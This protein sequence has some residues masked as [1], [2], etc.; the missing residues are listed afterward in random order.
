MT[1][2]LNIDNKEATSEN[3]G[4]DM[5]ILTEMSDKFDTNEAER[6][7][8]A[9]KAKI[10]ESPIAKEQGTS[11]FEARAQLK[12]FFEQKRH[13]ENSDPAIEEAP[14]EQSNN[15][16]NTAKP[17]T[18]SSMYEAM[19][20]PIIDKIKSE[21]QPYN[22]VKYERKQVASQPN[23]LTKTARLIAHKLGLETKRGKE[24]R[25]QEAIHIALD[26]YRE[27]E[28]T[29]RKALEERRKALEERKK[30]E[31]LERAKRDAE[32]KAEMAKIEKR[33]LARD[34]ETAR[35]VFDY[36]KHNKFGKQRIQEIVE[37]GLNSRLLTVDGL[38]ME[39]ISEN[40]E[41]QKRSISFEDADIPV[42]DLKGFPFSF[43]STTIDY[44]NA[45]KPGEIGTETFEKILE[46]PSIWTERRDEAEKASG[47]GTRNSDARG[48][49]ISTSYWNSERNIDSRVPGNLIYGFESV[50][51]DSIISASNGDGATNNMAGG[52]KTT[53]SSPNVIERLEGADG[54]HGYNEILLR[55][56]TENGM[57]K[58]PDYI[59]T[60]NGKITE[61]S[62]RHAKYFD[63]PI[64]NIDRSVYA[65]KTEKRGEE[66]LASI[67]EDDAYEEIDEKIAELL[68]ISKYK[69]AYRRLEGIGRNYDIPHLI[70]PTPL[71]KRCLEISQMEQLKRLEFIKNALEEATDNIESATEKGLE[72]EQSFPKFESFDIYIIDVR[73]QLWRTESSDQKDSSYSA[74]GNCNSINIDFRLKGSSR[75]VT[76]NVYDGAR[77]YKAEEA[78]NQTKEDMQN[79][80]SSYYEA[81]EPTVLKYFEAVRK[82]QQLIGEQV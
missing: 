82:N 33:A 6:L 46:D 64:V 45:N 48:D 2:T 4:D 40:P 76:T 59:I 41:I 69:K 67:N 9:E 81:L 70:N 49:T 66:L 43:L 73:D 12:T 26:E 15:Q 54:T 71:E 8:E 13:D 65:E 61:E 42:Y 30:A 5:K 75:H 24:R 78:S 68:S 77:I 72:M 74:P 50:R 53:L 19:E 55:R 20:R 60:E 25:E 80:D 10:N 58:K 35:S 21:I 34:M 3:S 29:R 7:T 31:A 62:L 23:T 52:A 22:I 28:A 57:P 44:R 47:F 27:E 1:E 63:I 51:A 56:Y 18:I 36:N 16:Q 39:V 37:R 14:V 32:Y 38:E 79:G 11:L 17:K